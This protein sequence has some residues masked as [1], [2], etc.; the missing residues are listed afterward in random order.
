MWPST[1]VSF[2]APVALR[3]QVTAQPSPH[4]RCAQASGIPDLFQE[5]P[6]NSGRLQKP[7]EGFQVTCGNG[8]YKAWGPHHLQVAKAGGDSSEEVTAL[9]Q[10]THCK[11]IPADLGK[12][13]R[14]GKRASQ[15]LLPARQLSK[16]GFKCCC[17]T[18][19]WG[20]P[21]ALSS[22]EPNSRADS[23][24]RPSKSGDSCRQ[25]CS[26]TR[27]GHCPLGAHHRPVHRRWLGRR[28]RREAAGGAGRSRTACEPGQRA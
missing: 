24:E 1:T 13:G 4:R 14:G 19:P 12:G 2:H 3:E 5:I 21:A 10:L 22:A 9:S 11:D 20:H 7:P 15:A 18:A 16:Q 23:R 25:E 8:L 27:G 26:L 6:P 28:G 17:L